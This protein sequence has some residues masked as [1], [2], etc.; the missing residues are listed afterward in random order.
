[1]SKEYDN[2]MKEKVEQ[3]IAYS[4]YVAD[5][6]NQQLQSQGKLYEKTKIPP[7]YS[8]VDTFIKKHKINLSYKNDTKQLSEPDW[9]ED[10]KIE[11]K[12]TIIIGVT[13]LIISFL[14]LIL[15]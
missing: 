11:T 8:D 4:E 15:K 6:L 3:S 12:I 1:M 2:Y 10:L 5:A 7:G 13:G 9:W 14:T